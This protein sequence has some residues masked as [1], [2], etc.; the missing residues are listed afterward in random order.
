MKSNGE[1]LQY[2][3]TLSPRFNDL[4]DEALRR[5]ITVVTI[6]EFRALWQYYNPKALMDFDQFGYVNNPDIGAERVIG[7]DPDSVVR[8]VER[9]NLGICEKAF[10]H[11]IGH[12]ETRSRIPLCYY[13]SK[14]IFFYCGFLEAL[15]EKTCFEILKC[16]PPR[17]GKPTFLRN[18]GGMML[19]EF[20]LPP[21][22]HII[23]CKE[24]DAI[25]F[26]KLRKCPKLR[27]TRKIVGLLKKLLNG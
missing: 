11:E 9:G 24:C 16:L 23:N 15:A 22:E 27:E 1:L 14:Y 17:E 8:W 21:K 4:V 7:I 2:L 18:T 6:A 19:R 10:A 26:H 25:K 3:R 12:D 5:G 20:A 13:R